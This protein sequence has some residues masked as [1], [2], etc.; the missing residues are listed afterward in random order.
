[1]EM[2][3]VHFRYP[4]RADAP[5]LSGVSLTLD[6]EAPLALV[7]PSGA[8]KST[9]A[10]LLTRLYEPN[11]GAITLDGVDV[12]GLS[13]AWLRTQ[14]AVVSQEPVLFAQSILANITC[15]P[16]GPTLQAGSAPLLV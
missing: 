4:S 7:G 6:P 8:G 16:P 5:V 12:R 1:M 13:A 15:R 9:V 14:I 3:D 11:A 10:A 2:K